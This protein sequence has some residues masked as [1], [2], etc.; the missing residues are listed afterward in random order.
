MQTPDAMTPGA[1]PTVDFLL[2]HLSAVVKKMR[3]KSQHCTPWVH[4]QRYILRYIK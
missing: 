4:F 3:V 2:H 1:I